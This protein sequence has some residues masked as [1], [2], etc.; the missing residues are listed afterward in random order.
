MRI[1]ATF[2]FTKTLQRYSK[3]KE[4]DLNK[5]MRYAK[6]L[7]VDKKVRDYMEVLL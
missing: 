4:K 5:L 1:N 7:K 2:I 6:K 3:S